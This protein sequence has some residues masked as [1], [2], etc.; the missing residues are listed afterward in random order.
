METKQI[1]QDIEESGLFSTIDDEP[2]FSWH[3]G[4]HPGC[5]EPGKGNTV[6]DVKGYRNLKEAQGNKD[7]YYKFRIC[8]ECFYRMNY[9][10]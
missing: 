2:Y 8:E 7:N 1:M 4:D 3:G 6:Y 10:D 9:G 5:S